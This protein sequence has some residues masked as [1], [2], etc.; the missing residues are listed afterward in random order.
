MSRRH[1]LGCGRVQRAWACDPCAGLPDR[2]PWALRPGV[3]Q[4]LLAWLLVPVLAVDDWRMG[5]RLS[6]CRSKR[7]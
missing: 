2:R 6:S 4:A 3:L 7:S 1:C 5:R